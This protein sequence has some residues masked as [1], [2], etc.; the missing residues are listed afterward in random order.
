MED[1]P[2]KLCDFTLKQLLKDFEERLEHLKKRKDTPITNGRICEAQLG[3]LH[4]QQL[5]LDNLGK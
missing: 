4:I 2:Q 3:V 1:K 5:I